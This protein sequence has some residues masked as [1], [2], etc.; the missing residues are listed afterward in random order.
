M[1]PQV[2]KIV[3]EQFYT[4]G[5]I[6]DDLVPGEALDTVLNILSETAWDGARGPAQTARDLLFPLLGVPK[7]A[8]AARKAKKV[9]EEKADELE[10]YAAL[11]AE[12]GY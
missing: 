5:L 6:I 12:M 10:S 4:V 1:S 3:A 9:K 8:A 2:R 7:P 11:V